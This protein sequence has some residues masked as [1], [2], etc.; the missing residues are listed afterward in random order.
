MKTCNTCKTEKPL[1]DF[2]KCARY[3]D[4]HQYVCRECK[5][6]YNQRTKEQRAE[7]KRGYRA[8][9]LDKVKAYNNAYNAQYKREHPEIV[10]RHA[11]KRRALEISQAGI[12]PLRL[13]EFLDN[14]YGHYCFKCGATE[15]IQLDHIVPLSK[16]GL[17]CVNNV[18]W[19]CAYC[20][21]VKGNRNSVDY[22]PMPVRV[23][24]PTK[25]IRLSPADVLAA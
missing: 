1:S 16:G 24:I 7:W 15:D 12:M 4:G 8:A 11:Q 20:N 6:A 5:R 21:N 9:N 2:N 18:Q 13:E 22:R 23:S 25:V 3:K 19:L 10:R 17:H 14:F